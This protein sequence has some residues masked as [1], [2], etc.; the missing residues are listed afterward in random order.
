MHDPRLAIDILRQI[1]GA[2]KTILA[3]FQPIA[4]GAGNCPLIP[5]LQERTDCKNVFSEFSNSPV[6]MSSGLTA[7]YHSNSGTD[8]S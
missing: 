6:C 4:Y 7:R 5:F 8:I 1:N 3:R 2:A